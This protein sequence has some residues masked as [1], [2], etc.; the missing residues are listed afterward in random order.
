MINIVVRPDVYQRYRQVFRLEPLIVVEGT[1]QK[2]DGTLNIIARA[3]TPL[4]NE[5]GRQH[6]LPGPHRNYYR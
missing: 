4:R 5:I 1:V 2:R 6:N 3:L